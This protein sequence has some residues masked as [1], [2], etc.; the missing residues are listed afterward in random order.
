LRR[1]ECSDVPFASFAAPQKSS[2]LLTVSDE[3]PYGTR[4]REPVLF[5]ASIAD[6]AP[7]FEMKEA[8]N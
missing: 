3:P 2:G 4:C 6:I 7:W 8:A 1:S 5:T